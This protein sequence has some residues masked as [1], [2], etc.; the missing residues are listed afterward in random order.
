VNATVPVD[1]API[2]PEVEKAVPRQAWLLTVFLMV[3][4]TFAY[5]DKQVVSILV[6]PLKAD[7][8]LSDVEI[9]LLQGFAFSACH[10]LM[11]VPLAILLDRGDRVR[12]TSWCIAIWSVAT[13]S[14]ALAGA[15]ASLLASRALTAMGEAGL[16]PAALSLIRDRFP[17]QL[18]SRAT[19]LFMVGPYI[20]MG[21]ALLG[22]GPLLVWLATRDL[23][24]IAPWRMVFV[25][26]GAPGLILAA[27]MWLCVHEPRR[28]R[29]AVSSVRPKVEPLRKTIAGRRGFFALM[30]LASTMACVPM[31][32]QMA[33]MPTFLIRVMGLSPGAAGALIGPLYIVA[34]I[35]GATGAAVLTSGARD[36]LRRIIALL[37][38]ATGSLIVTASLAPFAGGVIP[39]LS[40]FALSIA[41]S[42]MIIALLPTPIQL[43]APSD[44]VARMM[45]ILNII[46]ALGAAGIG[47]LA[48]GI[49]T[50][51]VFADP[52]ALGMS[53]AIT[54]GS[55]SIAGLALFLAAGARARRFA[56]TA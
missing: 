39:I 20:G 13:M 4:F 17:R 44:A 16:T 15:F 21:V 34:G 33:W 11:G 24:G 38:A 6:E 12:I 29:L 27:V 19:A 45:V 10:A 40:L 46:L 50:D 48:V 54:C 8:G 47:P 18:M 14:C 7:L 53:I 52:M 35:G 36:P 1:A 56:A 22:G 43:A 5:L 3:C 2:V 41:A 37:A 23:G 32:A 30:F 9:G 28:A 55:S 31:Y 25:I 42:S 26:V 51:R 49:F